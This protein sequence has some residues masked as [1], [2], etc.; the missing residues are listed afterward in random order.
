MQ[1][2][3]LR[4]FSRLLPVALLALAI[5]RVVFASFSIADVKVQFVLALVVAAGAAGGS[6]R[7]AVAGFVLGLLVDLSGNTPVGLVALAYGLGGMT[8]GYI[9]TLAPDAQWYLQALFAGLGAAVGEAAIP[10]VDVVAGNSGWMTKEL[11]VEVPVVALAAML[12]A[13]ALM[14]PGRWMMGVKRKKW[15]A[16]PE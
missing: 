11:F 9:Q 3:S 2:L 8:A 14:W 15:K 16:I 12:F 6:D 7:G 4:G 5:Q 13:P 1:S 10:A